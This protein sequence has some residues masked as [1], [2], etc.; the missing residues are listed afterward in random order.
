MKAKNVHLNFPAFCQLRHFFTW[1]GGVAV[2]RTESKVYF[3]NSK[4]IVSKMTE[5]KEISMILDEKVVK[6]FC[7]A[8]SFKENDG[9]KVNSLHFSWNGLS[10]ITSSEDDQIVIYDCERGDQKRLVNSQKYG[11]DLA[12]FTH[13]HNAAIHASTKR[14]D[15]IRYLSL[16]DN[17]FI[18]YFTGHTKKVISLEMSPADDTFISG[19][20][21]NS[22]RL[23]DLR[24]PSCI[25]LMTVTGKPV[26]A[27]DPEGLVFS[28]G[29]NSEQV[30]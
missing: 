30:H 7:V 29:V 3:E 2:R 15:A 10:L 27:F 9:G 19:G 24:T 11:V 26:C 18:R 23:W 21:D 1:R 28:V 14:D 13:A 20:L 12:R 4:K 25:G 16:H 17:K 6:T 5:H 8:K 22:V